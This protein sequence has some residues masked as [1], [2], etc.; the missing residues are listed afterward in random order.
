MQNQTLKQ[1]H[2]PPPNASHSQQLRFYSTKKKRQLAPRWSK[3]SSNEYQAARKKI[4]TADVKLCAVCWKEDD[5]NNSN[6]VLWIACTKCDLWMHK[7]CI[8]MPTIENNE[9]YCE[10]ANSHLYS[11][12]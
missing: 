5:T 10:T 6:E 1:L 7:S 3:P 11:C 2:A 4:C 9:F 8:K 12:I